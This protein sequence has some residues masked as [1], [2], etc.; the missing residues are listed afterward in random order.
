MNMNMWEEMNFENEIYQKLMDAQIEA[1]SN[2]KRLSHDD[3]FKPLRQKI[4]DHMNFL[5][6]DWNKVSPFLSTRIKYN[7]GIY[8]TYRPIKPIQTE[9]RVLTVKN[10]LVFYVIL[11]EIIEIHRIV[12]KKRNLSQLIK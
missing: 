7:S 8:R 11:G 6:N 3:V 4:T 10:Y 12:Y 5:K 2:P 1:R 9:Y